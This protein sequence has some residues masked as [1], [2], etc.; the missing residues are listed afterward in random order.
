MKPTLKDRKNKSGY[1]GGTDEGCEQSTGN[2][3]GK[4]KLGAPWGST[5]KPDPRNHLL[6][7]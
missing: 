3:N 5:V 4:G 7:K 6:A 2:D 1:G